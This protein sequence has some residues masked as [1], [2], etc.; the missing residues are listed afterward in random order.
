MNKKIFAMLCA[1]IFVFSAFGGTVMAQNQTNIVAGITPQVFFG[2]DISQSYFLLGEE[3]SDYSPLTDGRY[4]PNT[5]FSNKE[6]VTFYR[7]RTREIVFVLD[8]FYA[9][10]G[11]KVS[12]LSNYN[13]G[14]YCPRFCNLYVSENGVDYMKAFSLGD[15]SKT[16]NSVTRMESYSVTD[17]GRYK[18]KY[19]KI[20][21]DVIVNVYCDEI[22]VYGASPDGTEQPF[23][24]DTVTPAQGYDR[25]AEGFRDMA[26][27]Y[28][29][30]DYD[31]DKNHTYSSE[32]VNATEE[33]ML[34]Y[35]AYLDK[36]GNI[37]DTMFDSV[38]FC[39]LQGLCPSGGKL[40]HYNNGYNEKGDWETFA[41]SVFSNEYNASALDKAVGRVKESLN[42]PDYKLR[43][44][45][46]VPCAIP[47]QARDFGDIDGDGVP[48]RC[49]TPEQR[50]AIYK[51]YIDY[52]I[53]L[54]ESK[55]YENLEFGGF[56]WT[57]ESVNYTEMGS[58]V[59]F[60]RSVA[61]YCHEKNLK[62]FWI[63]FYL[64]AGFE[65]ANDVFDTAYMQP[66]H[67]FL[68]YS[69]QGMFTSF[70]ETI[71]K[72]GMGIEMEI[73]WDA[74]NPSA[75]GFKDAL[76]RYRAYLNYGS[77]TGYMTGAAHAYYQNSAPGTFYTACK[78]SNPELRAVYDDTYSFIKGT[79]VYNSPAI[80]VED[81]EHSVTS[82][83]RFVGMIRGWD[84]NNDNEYV[85]ITPPS[86]GTLKIDNSIG[87]YTYKAEL[88]YS[89]TDSFTVKLFDG[90]TYS[91]PLTV[92]FTI[93]APAPEE[94]SS[95]EAPSPA[96]KS[97]SN[98]W[99][100]P[101]AAAI[102]VIIAATATVVILLNKKKKK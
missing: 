39:S 86:H 94:S 98:K 34:P 3:A 35:V 68:A 43:L 37:L 50:L 7:G 100:L 45:V 9:V 2:E 99:L 40:Y 62:L 73:H 88:G 78:S 66:N 93:N 59:P 26:V 91:E 77:I 5:T 31:A 57:A 84:Q 61:D 89:G 51:W 76:K 42:R 14:I 27:L 58:D 54:F 30:Y 72:Y 63:P 74:A 46:A 38:V 25:G 85:V 83:N 81:A 11:F 1:V 47:G 90:Y 20:E 102:G 10:T 92:S 41:Q 22:E 69:K 80:Y 6:Y 18:A 17:G 48:E 44:A 33:M 23:V 67:S 64:A 21:F 15:E 55:S 32:Y 82:G 4:S 36:N 70:A 49:D 13:A 75:A 52:V 19:I 96:E 87:K 53:A 12:F 56:Y 60:M 16:G 28:C 101:A 97:P 24:K 79:Y 95:P 29:G 8:D 65:E 71:N